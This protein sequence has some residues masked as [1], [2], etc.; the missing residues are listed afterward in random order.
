MTAIYQRAFP[1]AKSEPGNSMM[2][3]GTIRHPSSVS[4]RAGSIDDAEKK[5]PRMRRFH[6]GDAVRFDYL[7]SIIFFVVLNACEPLLTAVMRQK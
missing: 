7:T 6:Q 4:F 2:R 5:P 3:A 1:F